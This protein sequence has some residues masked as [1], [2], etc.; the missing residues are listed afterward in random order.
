MT[1]TIFISDFRQNEDVYRTV[2]GIGPFKLGVIVFSSSIASQNS[3]D[4]GNPMTTSKVTI[5]LYHRY[6][7]NVHA[8]K[9]FCQGNG[10]YQK[11]VSFVNSSIVFW[12]LF[13]KLKEK[14]FVL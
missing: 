2:F 11:L 3:F 7:K 14:Y 4:S 13:C 12:L 9:T 10:F 1:Q 8:A 5:V 6:Y